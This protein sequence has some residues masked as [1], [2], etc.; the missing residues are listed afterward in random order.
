MDTSPITARSLRKPYHIKGDEFERAYKE[1]LSGFRTWKELAHAEDWLVFYKN[2]GPNICIDETSL[3][4][5]ELYTI[6][7]NKD[8]HGGK[9]AIIAIIKGTKVETVV[10]ALKHILWYERAKVLEVTMDFSESMRS[11]VEQSIPY[12][13]IT[14]DRFHV[15]KDCCDAM[16]QLRVKYRRQAQRAEAKARKDV[17]LRNKRYAERRK[18]YLEKNGGKRKGNQGRKPDR[19]N[20]KYESKKLDNGDT[21]CE[22]LARSRYLLMTSSDKW[23]DAQKKRAKIL[24]ELYPNLETAYS[25]THSLRMIFSNKNATKTSGLQ[26]LSEWYK[27]VDAFGDKN[28]CAVVSTIKA[29]QGEVLYYFVNRATN[30]AAESFHSKIK[31]FRAQ[32]HGVIDVKFFLFRLTN[33]YA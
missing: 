21:V 24:F 7:T 27:K 29:R 28:F 3:S 22:L 5:G 14:I 33:I 26:S 17:K 32:L 15:Q 4:D 23:T 19:K 20:R 10:E 9:G 12:A 25:I 11:I 18:K 30:A 8:A 2:I 31:L 1:F 16:Q 13:T 6:V